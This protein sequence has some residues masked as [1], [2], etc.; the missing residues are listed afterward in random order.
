VA[1]FKT[2]E[3]TVTNKNY[4]DEEIKSSLNVGNAC[5]HSIQTLVSSLLLSKNVEIKRLKET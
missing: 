2:F 4:I 5:C 1:K 3:R